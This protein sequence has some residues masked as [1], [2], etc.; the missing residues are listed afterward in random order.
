M[1]CVLL[2]FQIGF[3]VHL[4]ITYPNC[5]HCVKMAELDKPQG[6]YYYCAPQTTR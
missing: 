3:G 2:A 5:A 4:P 6:Y 1:T